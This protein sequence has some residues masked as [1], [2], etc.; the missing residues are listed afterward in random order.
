MAFGYILFLKIVS[1]PLTSKLKNPTMSI[2][3]DKAQTRKKLCRWLGRKQPVDA[4]LHHTQS[5]LP[6]ELKD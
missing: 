5:T 3:F 1:F 6:F 2:H 4:R